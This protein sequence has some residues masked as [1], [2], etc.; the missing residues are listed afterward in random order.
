[1]SQ[2]NNPDPHEEPEEFLERNPSVAFEP[3]DE[4]VGSVSG[5]GIGLAMGI[6]V[7]AFAMWGLFEWFYARE[8]KA[9]PAV[10]P[11]VLSEKPQLPPEPRLQAVPRLDLKAL[12]DGEDEVLNNYAWVDPDHGIARIPIKEAIKIVAAKGL[13]SKP[14][15]D[16]GNAQGYREL[17]SVASSARTTEKISQ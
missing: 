3:A 10:A 5:F 1:M 7:V 13:P 8:D 14:S 9:Y 6:V 4:N 16:L 17:P 15:T 2:P 12:H 11:V